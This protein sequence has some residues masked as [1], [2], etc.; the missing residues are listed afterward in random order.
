M[1]ARDVLASVMDQWQAGIDA[2][3]PARVAA[4]FTDE[5]IFQGLRPYSVGRQRVADYYDSQP[6]GMTV[7]Y[8]VLETRRPATDVVHG[9]LSAD[10]AFLDRPTVSLHI[11]VLV[12]RHNGGWRIGQ[13]QAS[14]I[15]TGS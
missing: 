5:T 4:L 2:H 7:S 1:S 15:D 6:R 8:R 11:G 9:Y 3:E 13:Y 10:F 14:R 12:T